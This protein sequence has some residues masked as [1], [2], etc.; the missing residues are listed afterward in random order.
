MNSNG[1]E[2]WGELVTSTMHAP[3]DVD[4]RMAISLLSILIVAGIA[5]AV[6]LPLTAMP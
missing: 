2:K 1:M 6:L 5:G 3:R 4:D